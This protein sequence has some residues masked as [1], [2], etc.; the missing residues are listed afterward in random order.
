MA[1]TQTAIDT[2]NVRTLKVGIIPLYTNFLEDLNPVDEVSTLAV[3]DVLELQHS[4]G[5]RTTYA[6]SQSRSV[7]EYCN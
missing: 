7:G 3:E 5:N 2:D 1:L 6:V 4:T